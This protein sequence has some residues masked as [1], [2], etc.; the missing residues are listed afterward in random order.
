MIGQTGTH[1]YF[2]PVYARDTG[3]ISNNQDVIENGNLK[4]LTLVLMPAL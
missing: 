1:A 4:R 3:R 2:A